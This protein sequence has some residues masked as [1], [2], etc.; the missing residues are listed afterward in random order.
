MLVH[1]GEGG[2]EGVGGLL[3]AC[4]NISCY[5]IWYF[6][7]NIAHRCHKY[8]KILLLFSL[9]HCIYMQKLNLKLQK[10]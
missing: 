5:H 8:S 4:Q 9:F 6:Q 2:G 10:N 3:Q 7:L 1:K